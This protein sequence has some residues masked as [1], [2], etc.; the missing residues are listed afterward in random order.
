METWYAPAIGCQAL[1]R[2][3]R[4]AGRDGQYRTLLIKDATAVK[5]GEPEASKFN[6]PSWPERAPSEI[7]AAHAAKYNK[8]FGPKSWH[9]KDSAY[10]ASHQPR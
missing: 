7:A 4:A 6:V 3:V 9:A 8:V 10:Y 1:R 5:L 2:I